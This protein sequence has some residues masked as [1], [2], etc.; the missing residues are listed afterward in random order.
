MTV[1]LAITIIGS[2]QLGLL[3]LVHEGAHGTLTR[4]NRLNLFV[5]DWFCAYPMLA[6][7][8]AY[9]TTHLKHHVTTLQ[10][11]DPDLHITA[12]YPTTPRGLSLMLLRDLCGLTFLRDRLKQLRDAWGPPDLAP[13]PRFARLR[14]KL[15]GQLLANLVLLG[16][17]AGTGAWRLYLLL[18]WLPMITWQQAMRT[19][20]S[21]AAHAVVSDPNDPR[22]HAR[23]TLTGPIGRL[24]VF[25]YFSNY[26]LDHHIIAYA[27]CYRMP[28]LHRILRAGPIGNQMEIESGLPAVVMK[29]VSLRTTSSAAA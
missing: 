20:L 14:A 12:G 15:G 28:E 16:I 19:L 10:P 23:T 4:G 27:P 5:S 9:R 24:F 22:H 11:D 21:A 1:L 26:H 25:P 3:Y 17:A 2:R 13:A 29:I 7:T 6:D 18:W 8:I